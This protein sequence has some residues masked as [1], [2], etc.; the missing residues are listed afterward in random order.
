MPRAAAG[1]TT[2]AGGTHRPC[3]GASDLRVPAA[4]PG[5]PTAS[6]DSPEHTSP[7][8]LLP[9]GASLAAWE[10]IWGAHSRLIYLSLRFLKPADKNPAQRAPFTKIQAFK[11]LFIHPT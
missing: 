3:C 11:S 4:Q 10:G 6:A 8:Q 9:E 7:Q 1:T 5:F 2:D